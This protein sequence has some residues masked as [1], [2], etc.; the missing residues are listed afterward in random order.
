[1]KCAICGTEFEGASCPGCNAPANSQQQ[2]APQVGKPK[3][4]ESRFLK[5]GGFG[6]LQ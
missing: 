1:M 4:Q 2:P 6:L 3:N 5:D